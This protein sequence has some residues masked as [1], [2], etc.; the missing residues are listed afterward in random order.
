MD[1]V[2]VFMIYFYGLQLLITLGVPALV[3]YDCWFL[4]K[5]DRATTVK[6][7]GGILAAGFIFPFLGVFGLIYY[8]YCFYRGFPSWS[9][10]R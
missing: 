9:K 2:F 4:Q 8:I 3:A 5:F 1:K 10:K 6:W 7:A